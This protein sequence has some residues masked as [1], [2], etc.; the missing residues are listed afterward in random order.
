[1]T[2]FNIIWMLI[3]LIDFFG[4]FKWYRTIDRLPTFWEVTVPFFWLYIKFRNAD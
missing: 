3:L 2:L 1:M 4:Y